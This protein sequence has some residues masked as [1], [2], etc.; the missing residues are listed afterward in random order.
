V[1]WSCRREF[2]DRQVRFG[3]GR[4]VSYGGGDLT[5]LSGGLGVTEIL[6]VAQDPLIAFRVI[7]ADDVTAVSSP[8]DNSLWRWDCL[9]GP[10]IRI[11]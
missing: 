3:G 7:L 9:E 2:P 5:A 4:R 11:D 1:A 6:I 8:E 10:R